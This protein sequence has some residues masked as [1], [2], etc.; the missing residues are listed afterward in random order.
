MRDQTYSRPKTNV[1]K[2]VDEQL[3]VG[4]AGEND[5]DGRRQSILAH[6][7]TLGMVCCSICLLGDG[8]DAGYLDGDRRSM[9]AILGRTLA[10]VRGPWIA[11][12]PG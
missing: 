11:C 7:S 12:F 9:P 5:D 2:F 3:A 6:R 4:W 8:N 10:I 1:F